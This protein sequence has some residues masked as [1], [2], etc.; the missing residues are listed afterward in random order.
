[1]W[2]QMLVLEA[3]AAA[4]VLGGAQV[5]A[6]TCVGA[7][8][9]RNLG[10]AVLRSPWLQPHNIRSVGAGEDRNLGGAVLRS[11]WLQHHNIRSGS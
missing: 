6:A 8:E 3:A 2:E 7:G 4:E 5:V 9:D 1:M 11:P 10:A